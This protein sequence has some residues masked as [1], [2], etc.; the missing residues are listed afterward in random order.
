MLFQVIELYGIYFN[1]GSSPS[2]NLS[3]SLTV[4]RYLPVVGLG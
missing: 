4:Y 1:S 2:F 3:Q